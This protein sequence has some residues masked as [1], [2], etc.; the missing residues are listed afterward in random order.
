MRHRIGTILFMLI[1]FTCLGKSENDS[2]IKKFK[3]LKLYSKNSGTDLLAIVMPLILLYDI[4]KDRGNSQSIFTMLSDTQGLK[5]IG[6]V[7]ALL[8]CAGCVLKVSLH[9]A[10]DVIN[11][12]PL[13][14]AS[15]RK[16]MQYVCDWVCGCTD[17]LNLQQLLVHEHMFEQ[18]TNGL[19]EQSSS[20]ALMLRN[21][22]VNEQLE[23]DAASHN[24]SY[25]VLM[26]EQTASFIITQLADANKYY[27]IDP[28]HTSTAEFKNWYVQSHS[29]HNQT[30]VFLLSMI[31]KNIQHI[32]QVCKQATGNDDVDTAHI[33]KIS[34]TTLLAFKKLR[35]IACIQHDNKHISGSA[36]NNNDML[37]PDKKNGIELFEF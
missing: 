9:A 19:C 4:V 21:L 5:D 35:T 8:A 3:D 37:M 36:A 32:V 29:S 15:V 13:A 26:L 16:S 22:R 2:A 6:K 28:Q 10:D 33:K 25:H 1:S 12:I 34:R 11:R 27:Q 17:P 7:I 31:I 20:N 14:L 18:I 30:I 24:W 23:D